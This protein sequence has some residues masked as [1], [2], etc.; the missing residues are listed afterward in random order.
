MA[1][2]EL[3]FS[4]CC[5]DPWNQAVE[6]RNLLPAPIRAAADR[7]DD[8]ALGAWLREEGG[9]RPLQTVRFMR[10]CDLLAQYAVAKDLVARLRFLI[11]LGFVD[12][13]ARLGAHQ[14]TLLHF[15]A[16]FT[17][18]KAVELLLREG[19]DVNAETGP[20]ET[21]GGRDRGERWTPLVET[22]VLPQHLRLNTFDDYMR[23]G[24]RRHPQTPTPG[25]PLLVEARAR[26]KVSRRTPTSVVAASAEY[27]RRR[28]GV[29][30]ICLR[31]IS[32]RPRASPQ[33]RSI[34]RV[35]QLRTRDRAGPSGATRLPETG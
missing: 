20:L 35:E 32:A 16:R 28:R 11:I 33:A 26:A 29:A 23:P 27:P 30:A 15:A 1:A 10:K 5:I 9:R 7:S 4:A 6:P 17:S 18:P 8:A 22:T 31:G 12:V 2:E 25:R 19:A 3:D 13:R 14:W 24:S 21:A 34:A